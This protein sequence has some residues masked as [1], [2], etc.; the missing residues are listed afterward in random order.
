MQ[1]DTATTLCAKAPPLGALASFPMICPTCGRD[2]PRSRFRSRNKLALP[3]REVMCRSCEREWW[4]R[5]LS[6]GRFTRPPFGKSL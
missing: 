6:D 1:S 2:R 5:Q 3:G 4:A